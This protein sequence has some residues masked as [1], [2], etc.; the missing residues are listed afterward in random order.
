MEPREVI[1]QLVT[2]V[3]PNASVAAFE[4][5]D[6]NCR[7]TLVGTTGVTAACELP[8]AFVQN[9][10]AERGAPERVW[11]RSRLKRCADDVVAAPPD[12]R[13]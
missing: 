6:A 13:A 7:V 3:A 9:A 4:E 12:G 1:E 5:R 2:E 11:L 8:R 10:A